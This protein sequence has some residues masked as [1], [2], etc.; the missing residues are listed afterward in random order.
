MKRRTFLT[1]AAA[2]LASPS[3]IGQS[4]RVYRVGL[5]N[6]G[7]PSPDTM[8]F[9]DA[10]RGRLRESGWVEGQNIA[11]EL[12]WSKGDVSRLPRM[13]TE[14][15][16]AGVD[17]IVAPSSDAVIAAKQA[18]GSIPIVMVFAINPVGQGLIASY[19]RPGGNV[20]GMTTEAGS[21]IVAKYL[22]ILRETIPSLRRVAV[23]W[24]TTSPVQRE[25]LR[26]MEQPAATLRLEVR[27]YGARA[28]E[29]FAPAF[30]RM[31]EEGCGALIILAD[32]F[33]F[34]HRALLAQLA[35]KH[36][37]P[38][39]SSV[40]DFVEEGGL[41]RYIADLLNLY[42]SAAGYVDRIL[43]GAKPAE[44]PVEQPTKFDL[45]INLK[46]ARTLGL[47]IPQAVLLR[48]NRVIE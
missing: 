32:S 12:Q 18:T 28:L 38:A 24:N 30:A 33:F 47:A 4:T 43:R 48:A 21:G 5:M 31:A 1:G 19:A 40:R 34:Q 11:Y 25:V 39:M 42:R 3:A 20:T 27:G 26:D 8:Q 46:T 16:R 35:L 7:A 36:R 14:L 13:A 2:L 10:V 45:V 9:V 29:D 6:G 22:D 23:L 44:L 17:V 15:V 41:M 37:L